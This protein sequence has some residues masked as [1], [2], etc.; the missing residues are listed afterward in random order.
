[1]QEWFFIRHKTENSIYF[2]LNFSTG[3]Y[4]CSEKMKINEKKNEN[5]N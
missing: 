4:V 5:K 3:Y 1:M 2:R